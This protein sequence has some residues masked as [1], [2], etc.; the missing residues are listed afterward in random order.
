MLVTFLPGL[1]RI[2]D[3]AGKLPELLGGALADIHRCEVGDRKAVPP[4]TLWSRSTTET[5]GLLS[6]VGDTVER[7]LSAMEPSDV[8]LLHGD[9]WTG[10]ILWRNGR[11]SG[12]VDWGRSC[13]GPR[14]YD[15]A[16]ARVDMDLLWGA[17]AA[18]RFTAAYSREAGPVPDLPLWDLVCGYDALQSAVWWMRGYGALG[19]SDLDRERIEGHLPDFL[20]RALA[21]A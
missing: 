21:R 6:D 14:G 11:V 3:D 15:V 1:T 12:V 17:D 13:I 7:G 9:F 4:E 8:T 18:E 20:R 16:Y 10:N 2:P 5:D 19:R